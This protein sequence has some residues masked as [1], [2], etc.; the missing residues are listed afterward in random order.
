MPMAREAPLRTYL[1]DCFVRGGIGKRELG[2]VYSRVHRSGDP[3]LNKL[4]VVLRVHMDIDG[5]P[6][7]CLVVGGPGV[8][9]APM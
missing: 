9:P 3:G 7:V 8:L 5:R 6:G 1:P 2:A 4:L